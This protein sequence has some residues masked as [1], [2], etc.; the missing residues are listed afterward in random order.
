MS[1]DGHHPASPPGIPRILHHDQWLV[2]FSKPVPMLSVPGIGPEK[3]DCLA[4]RAA[5]AFSGARIVHRLD[6]DTSGV[7]VLA[8]DA[9]THRTLSIQFQDR[10]VE[11]RYEAL[12]WGEPPEET[13]LIEAAI[14]K[15]LD[16]PP[17]QCVDPIQGKPSQ[18]VWRVIERLGD[19]TRLE[20]TPRTGR[21]HQ[22]RVHL[23]HIGHPI[24]GDDLYA[25]PEVV[26]MAPRL[27]L[28]ATDVT[29]THP[30]A[31]NRVSFH[32]AS[33]F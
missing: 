21:S 23:Q 7:I 20:L 3:A 32:D 1:I 12:V 26:A 13:G 24:L 22:L 6:R 11:K 25:P 18:T 15:D 19:H 2:V 17:R 28:H 8:L 4:S 10:L 31:G 14:R 5:E 27:C 33:P 9:D 30:V 16:N 29:V